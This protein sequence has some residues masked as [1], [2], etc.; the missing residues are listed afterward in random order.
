MPPHQS[1]TRRAIEIVEERVDREVTTERVFV[2]LAEDAVA[3]DEEILVLF[4]VTVG[5]VATE[6]GDLDDLA[7]TE[8]DGERG[9]S[10]GR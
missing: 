3:S 5:R 7:P 10:A 4:D 8:E 6:R 2:G 1:R 9:G